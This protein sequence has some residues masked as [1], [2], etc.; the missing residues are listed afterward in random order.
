MKRVTLQFPNVQV[1]WSF[2]KILKVQ[3][4]QIN[5]EKLQLVCQCEEALIEE[6]LRFY[7]AKMI[8]DPIKT[9]ETGK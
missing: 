8:A 6:A 4:F 9:N 3:E 1:L 7:K 5:T 2:A